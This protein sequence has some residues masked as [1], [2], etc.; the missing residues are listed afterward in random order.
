MSKTRKRATALALALLMA[1]TL[2]TAAMAATDWN[3]FQQEWNT[4]TVEMENDIKMEGPVTAEEGKSY[5]VNGNGH[6]LIDAV[7]QGKGKVEINADIE[8]EENFAALQVQDAKVEVNGDITGKNG[9]NGLN[10]NSD[11]IQDPHSADVTVNGDVRGGDLVDGKTDSNGDLIYEAGSGVTATAG[12]SVTVNGSVEGGSLTFTQ[13][14]LDNAFIPPHAGEGVFAG[15]EAS[16]TVTGSVKGGNLI[17]KPGVDLGPYTS[18]MDE[19]PVSAGYGVELEDGGSAFV[20]GDV[21]GG[22]LDAPDAA[23]DE[24]IS[25]GNGILINSDGERADVRGNVRGG[26]SLSG[27]NRGDTAGGGSG[28]FILGSGSGVSVGGDVSGGNYGAGLA[29]FKIIV[30][31]G[32]GGLMEILS[33]LGSFEV[34]GTL[35]GGKNGPAVSWCPMDLSSGSA[36]GDED[37]PLEDLKKMRLQDLTEVE[38]QALLEALRQNGMQDNIANIEYVYVPAPLPDE[39]GSE[40]PELLTVADAA[41][42]VSF[43]GLL[44]PGERLQVTPLGPDSQ[45]YQQLLSKLLP[46]ETLGPVYRVSIVGGSSS[47]IAQGALT[48]PGQGTFLSLD[49][50][51]ESTAGAAVQTAE[52]SLPGVF[53]LAS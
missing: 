15:E 5:T 41:T 6:T 52:V 21:T 51:F 32:Q 48:L 46:G 36:P 18:T 7:I 26:S 33:T 20:G 37:Y 28:V 40:D 43:T 42:G 4:G 14:P 53:A 16:V 35:R 31:D 39:D 11:N 19:V 24:L 50:R 44:F 25:A 34:G 22:N 10:A 9:A 3:E 12:A 2:P 49:G 47:R 8:S 23:A 45:E 30:P 13:D 1:A 27:K 17:V 29:V 38:Q